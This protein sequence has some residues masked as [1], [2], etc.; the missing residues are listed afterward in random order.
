MHAYIHMGLTLQSGG[1]GSVFFLLTGFHGLHVIL[2]T[3]FLIVIWVRMINGA[4]L[5]ENNFGYQA[6]VWYW[7]FVDIIWL[8]VFAFVYVF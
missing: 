1:Y 5:S 2:G 4:F 6:G 3:I 7:H 8:C